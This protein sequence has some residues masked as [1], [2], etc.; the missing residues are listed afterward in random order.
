MATVRFSNELRGSIL[1]RA[2]ALFTKRITDI[3][4]N[5]VHEDVYKRVVAPVLEPIAEKAKEIPEPFFSFTKETTVYV[6]HPQH[7]NFRRDYTL[8][9]ETVCPKKLY[10]VHPGLKLDS[11]YRDMTA[12]IS[13]DT[14]PED[15][16]E[17]ADAQCTALYTLRNEAKNF[18][19]SV[20][21]LINHYAT[22][23][24]ALKEWPPLWDLLD[25]SVQNRHK[26]V[27]EK[28]KRSSAKE[29]LDLSLDRMTGTVVA[30]KL[31]GKL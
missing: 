23:A 30:N 4:M 5:V 16:R 31:S 8:P 28:R 9:T 27:S 7:G 18:R 6:R 17:H 15:L 24:P 13:F 14:L 29:E 2:E 20:D 12:H 1:R 25:S 10:V 26:E 11:G 19:S 3:N 21:K 22:L